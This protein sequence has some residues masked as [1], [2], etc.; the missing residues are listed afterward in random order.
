MEARPDATV[1]RVCRGTSCS[2]HQSEKLLRDIEELCGVHANAETRSCM[3]R[4]GSAPNVEVIRPD[5]T[6]T[7]V[8]RVKTYDLAEELVT[9]N[10]PTVCLS[11]IQR[12]VGR[13]KYAYRREKDPAASENILRESFEL[14]DGCT[15]EPMLRSELLV[16]RA[17]SHLAKQEVQSALEDAK[18]SVT[19]APSWAQAYLVLADALEAVGDEPAAAEALGKA[20]GNGSNLGN[21]R[22]AIA[23]RRQ[24]LRGDDGCPE[25]AEWIVESTT[26]LNHNCILLTLRCVDVAKAAELSSSSDI[27]HVDVEAELDGVV[28]T[29]REY[30]EGRLRLMV[31]VYQDGLLTPFLAKLV[32]QD[33]LRVSAP[34]P[35]TDMANFAGGV[36]VVAGGSAVTVALQ[37]CASVLRRYPKRGLVRAVFCYR[38]NQDALFLEQIKK[39]LEEYPAFKV[40]YCISE[41]VHGQHRNFGG[42]ALWRHGNVSP[43]LLRN[44]EAHLRTVVSGPPGL[45]KAVAGMLHEIGR[46]SK[47]YMLLDCEDDFKDDGVDDQRPVANSRQ[48]A[49]KQPS[50]HLAPAAPQEVLTPDE[51]ADVKPRNCCRALIGLRWQ[52]ESRT[53]SRTPA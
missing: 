10:A 13:M 47:D 41:P 37:I 42:R 53:K 30:R 48:V 31:K 15:N 19:L 45:C 3:G 35:T 16:L 25:F 43:A 5:S 12:R 9:K 24:R 21:G 40:Y 52:P 29:T 34:I 14:L 38:L 26:P 6:S 1:F 27:W 20:L 17:R 36:V 44:M 2:S 46:S 7:C 23:Q 33:S 51:D 22:A 39:L 49:P 11:D 18:S 4:C 50:A 28:S 8:S 32:S